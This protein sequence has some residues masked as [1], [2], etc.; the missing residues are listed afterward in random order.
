MRNGSY[1]GLQGAGEFVGREPELEAL[2]GGLDQ[3]RSGRGTLFLV[4]GEPG[5]GKSRLADE[6]SA[7]ARE[8]GART[9]WGRCW[10]GAGAPAYWPWIQALRAHLR[11][12]DRDR[13]REH[14]GAGAADIAQVLPEIRTLV[15]DLPPPPPES[16][17]ARF[18]LFDSTTSFLRSIGREQETVL[19]LEDLQASDTPSILLLRFLASQLGDIRL[20]VVATYRD[21]E[22]TPDHPLTLAVSEM[23]REPVA[24]LLTLSGLRKADVSR[25]VE[26]TTGKSSQ[27]PLVARLWHETNG[28]PLFVSEA[29]RL[30]ASEGHLHETSAAD[31]LR[32]SLPAGVR[33]VITRRVRH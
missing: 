21:V 8:A 22:L 3:A 14:L 32:L 31:S 17:A 4:G 24:R 18:Q 20:L 23:A 33:E 16:D 13:A 9:L 6:F 7:R 26:T 30:L 12:I 5:I 25:F 15:P 19:I 27:A 1:A 10:E 28:N 2:I 11:N 29:M